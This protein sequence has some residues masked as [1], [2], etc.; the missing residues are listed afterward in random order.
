MAFPESAL[1]QTG[2]RPQPFQAPQ[3]DLAVLA[4]S[5]NPKFSQ[6]IASALGI[7]LLDCEA[8]YFSEGNVFVRIKEN[9]RGRDTYIIQGV[10]HPVNDNF[11]ELLFWVDALKR[12]SA[13]NVTAVIPYFSYAKGDKKD[14]PRVS[15]RA[16]VCADALEAAGAD[17]VLTM[18]LHSPQIQGFFSVPV[19]HLFA[20]QTICEHV[21]S[22][23]IPDLVV[24]SP[25]IG[26]AKDAASYARLLGTPVVIGNKQRVDHTESATVLEVIGDVKGSNVLMVDDFTISG[27]SL[28]GMAEVLKQRGAKEIYAAVSHGVLAKGAAAK[29]GGSVIKQMFITDTVENHVEPLPANMQVV[30]VAP[31]FARAIRSIHDRTS[32]S[33]LFPDARAVD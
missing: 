14:E 2:P 21:R 11:V 19:D 1:P 31:L 30:S 20:R 23:G 8:L 27:G 17:R 3:G 12:A 13:Q 29:I 22:L 25:D 32:V 6:A 4:G 7:R 10:S 15:I 5:A 28:I 16:R 18:D 24:C 9:V 26:F 33:M